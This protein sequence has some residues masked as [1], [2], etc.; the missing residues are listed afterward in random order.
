MTNVRTLTGVTG[1]TPA[2]E[3]L[4]LTVAEAAEAL[5]VDVAD[6]EA[7]I[8]AGDLPARRF[9]DEWRIGRVA[10]TDW[11]GESDIRRPAGFRPSSP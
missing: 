9:G 4:V 11:L 6:V 8:E 5:R 1:V 3:S 2:T 10:L 7:R